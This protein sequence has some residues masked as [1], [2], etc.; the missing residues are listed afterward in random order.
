[1]DTQITELLHSELR[2]IAEE[3]LR[4]ERKNHTIE[5]TALVKE[6]YLRMFA[7]PAPN[8]A[9][10]AHFRALASRIMRRILIDSA[11]AAKS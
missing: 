10:K 3:Y 1:M 6:A 4:R 8:I 11:R 5:P 7:T 9:D 2:G